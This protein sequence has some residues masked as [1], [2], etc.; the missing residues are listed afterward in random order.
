V[1]DPGQKN[2]SAVSR[3]RIV[4]VVFGVPAPRWPRRTLV[5]FT[6]AVA[7]HLSLWVWARTT[8][9]SLE[10]WSAEL[11]AK[12]HA[13]LSRDETIE[14]PKPPPPPPPEEP[15][16]EEPQPQ[17]IHHTTSPAKVSNPPPPARAAAVVARESNAPA[18]L[19]GETFVTGTA[20]A[21]AGGVTAATGTNTSAVQ[22]RNVNPNAPPGGTSGAPDRS[23]PVLL[24]SQSWSCPWPREA[25]A[26]EIDEQTVVIRV[27]VR[28]DGSVES[29]NVVSNPG[30][31]F[32]EAAASC[33]MKTRFAPAR[34]QR[35][36]PIRSTSP[37]IRV[38]FTR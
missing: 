30:H 18:D 15:K 28:P 20:N 10:S 11:A 36:A 31:G 24:P 13:E 37:P 5:A 8:K 23:S 27:V 9:R 16:A 22:T 35:G 21:Y 26:E 14:L 2:Q 1:I 17:P 7:A 32:G 29:A 25:D 38:R 34:D 33:A 4:D 19:T 12:V 3:P 6:V